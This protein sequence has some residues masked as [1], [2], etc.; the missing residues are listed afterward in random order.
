[1]TELQAWKYIAKAWRKDVFPQ[2]K[3]KNVTSSLRIGEAC[4][5]CHL[6]SWMQY[7]SRITQSICN[8]MERA[9]KENQREWD[10]NYRWPLNADGAKS[11]VKF[12]ERQIKRL[13]KLK[14]KGRK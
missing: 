2:Y 4:G 10:G 3:F 5:I 12:C 6:L 11:R 13:T 9:V 1:M 14:T 8:K 7:D